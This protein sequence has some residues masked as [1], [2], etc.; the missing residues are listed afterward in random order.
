[1]IRIRQYSSLSGP[2]YLESLLLPKQN[3][4]KFLERKDIW[5]RQCIQRFCDDEEKM[6]CL[7]SVVSKLEFKRKKEYILFFLENNPLFE[8]F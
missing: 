8:D 3:E 4:K 2:Q 6:Y 5:I 7:V 1:M